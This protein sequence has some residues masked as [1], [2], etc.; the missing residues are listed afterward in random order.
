VL[1]VIGVCKDFPGVRALDHVD[2]AVRRGEVHVLVGENGA[3]KSTLVK[4]LTGA[5]SKDAGTIQVDGEEMVFRRPA[6]AAARG[7]AAV[8][9][10][11]SLVPSLSVAENLFLGRLATRT[12]LGG[13]IRPIDWSFMNSRARQALK[14]FGVDIDPATKV[15]DVGVATEQL[16][17]IAKALSLDARILIMDEPTAALSRREITHLFG[18][19]RLLKDK[20]VSI[21][22]ISHRLDEIREVGDRATVLKDGRAIATVELSDVPLDAIV[23]M[24]VGR[25]LGDVFPDRKHGAGEVLLDVR[26]LTSHGKFEDV[27]L[28]VRSGEIVGITG[29]VGA[30]KTELARSIFGADPH[31]SGDLWLGGRPVVLESPR[32]AIQKGIGFLPEDRRAQGLVM[33][34]S[35]RH[36]VSLPSLSRFVHFGFIR[37]SK[38]NDAVSIRTRQVDIRP[39]DPTRRV[40]Y[41]SGG[42]QQKVV[43]AKWLTA[44][45][46]IYIFDEPTRGIDV[47]AKTE[48]YRLMGELAA[49]GKGVIMI[50]SDIPEILGICDR[51]L[52]LHLGKPA[53]EFSKDTATSERILNAAMIGQIQ[54]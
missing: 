13:L 28:H 34:L 32:R 24:M 38:E 39:S 43:L 48:I 15:R 31:D 51:I 30:G 7:I 11:F 29:L 36:N 8:F 16:I 50:S 17:E 1:E 53:A 52:V 5:Y 23:R 33:P 2:L 22:Y 46:A 41:L 44:E 40:E 20:G 25:E 21:I 47:G 27:S 42:N 14:D 54:A 10:E 19:V 49:A 37:P 12:R 4:I 26:H 9:Q 45:S 35:V 6:D 18:V 3:G